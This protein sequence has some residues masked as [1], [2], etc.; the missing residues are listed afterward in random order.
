MPLVASRQPFRRLLR[1]VA[2]S[3]YL[4]MEGDSRESRRSLSSRPLACWAVR[5]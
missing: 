3:L 4:A 2:R 1:E 5:V